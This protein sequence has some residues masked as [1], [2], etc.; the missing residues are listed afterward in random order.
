MRKYGVLAAAVA[1]HLCLGGIYAWSVFVPVLNRDFGYSSAQTQLV[2][3]LTV[4][5]L[6]AGSVLGGRLQDLLGPRIP[7]CLSGVLLWSGYMVA[8]HLGDRF[9]GLILGVS[10]LCGLGVGFGYVTS[11]AAAAKWFPDRRGLVT[12]VV[13]S[14]Y[15]CAAM[16]LSALAEVLLAH[17]W[18]VL[19]VFRIVG[20]VYG[21]TVLLAALALAVPAGGGGAV[22]AS[23]FRRSALLSDGRFWRLAIGLGCATYPGLALIGSL[24]PIGTWHGFDVVV[25]AASVSALAV[26]NGA[27]RITWGM[28]HDRMRGGNPVLLMMWA[29]LASVLV[30]AAGGVSA[31][32]FLG[33]AFLLGFCYGGSLAL[34]PS[35]V[36]AVYG[37]NVLG[38]VYPVV[39]ALH[40]LAAVAAAPLTGL[41]VDI[42]GGYWPGMLMACG[43]AVIG[44]AVCSLLPERGR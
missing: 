9:W 5:I 37:V 11:I 24:K 35:E 14:G 26:G 12:G 28:V 6:C 17:G 33:A 16:V 23:A 1:M 32:V 40:G 19:K 22:Q 18:P 30:F 29:V 21:P 43:M 15:G 27:G 7:A 39:L 41:G 25:A 36:A 20:S 42:T 13:V 44:I 38:S 34:F 2:F 10:V 4:A 8:G 3:G 31:P